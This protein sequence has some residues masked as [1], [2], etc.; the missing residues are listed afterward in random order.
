MKV[1]VR[2][3]ASLAQAAGFR[4]REME[5]PEGSTAGDLLVQLKRGPLIALTGARVL[6]AVNRQ[7]CDASQPLADGDEVGLFPPV[8]GGS[9]A[10]E[11]RLL[12]VSADR[13]DPGRL[14]DS[15]RH[16]SCGAVLTFEGVVRDHGQAGEVSAIEYEAYP[17]MALQVLRE[18]R[19]EVE[20]RYPGCRIAVAHR[21][22]RLLVGEPSVVVACAAAHRRDAFAACRLAMDRIKESLPVWKAEETPSGL[23][24]WN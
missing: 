14:A 13:L 21:T 7:H 10:D 9:G 20:A 24:S 15:V 22:G 11:E 18:L 1:R 12:I 5:V 17:E 4:E 3:F 6:H 23:R 2:L 19:D 8:S 16:P